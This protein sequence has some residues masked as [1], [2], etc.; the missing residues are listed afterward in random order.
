MYKRIS[1]ALLVFAA[2]CDR[3]STF[4]PPPGQ[5]LDAQL[6]QGIEFWGVVPI[7]PVPTQNPALVDLGQALFFDRILSGNRDVSCSTCHAPESQMNDGLSLA[8]GTGGSGIGPGRT[9]GAGRG[10]VPRNAPTILNV[11]LGLVYTLWDGRVNQ[12]F[13]QTGFTTPS[14]TVL[15]PGVQNLLAAQAMFPVLNRV[16]MRGDSGDV[17]V[18]GNPN[19]LAAIPASNAAAIWRATMTRLLAVSEYVSKFNAAYPGVPVA[20]LGFQHA[21]NAIAAFEVSAFTR[22]SSPF[23][24]YLLRD[25][26]ALTDEQKRGGIVFFGKGQCASCHSGA[27]LGG[28]QFVNIGVPQLGPGVG[29]AAPLDIGRGEQVAGMSQQFYRFN[30]RA[31]QLRNVELTAP[32][33]HNGAY[34][35]LENVV[36][37]YTNADS[38]LRN[39]DVSQLAPALRTTVRNDP[40]TI[41]DIL[42][43]LDFRLQA[44]RIQLSNVE[45]QEIVAFLK[46][47]TDPAAKT[48]THTIPP[49]VPSGLSVRD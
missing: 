22:S 11:G 24:R 19:E 6:R 3:I 14:N 20:S 21:A 17:D 42:T 16:E 41:A 39:Y 28:R 26:D 37:H 38:A 34:A 43:N 9:L 45:Q 15:P 2:G 31:P 12:E 18:F 29:A 13:G 23:D 33:M 36:R 49:S 4:E 35:T 27:L 10:F 46:S 8:V 7:D 44:R 40:A 5:A 30:F 48:L 25:N 32:Y 1:V 47:L